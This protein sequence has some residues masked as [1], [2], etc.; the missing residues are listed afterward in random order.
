MLWESVAYS[1]KIYYK[2]RVTKQCGSGIDIDNQNTTKVSAINPRPGNMCCDHSD[3]GHGLAQPVT[4]ENESGSQ[5]FTCSTKI[6][7]ICFGDLKWKTKLKN[8]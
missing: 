1:D 2:Y 8:I 7:I 3:R 5:P 6:S 4:Q